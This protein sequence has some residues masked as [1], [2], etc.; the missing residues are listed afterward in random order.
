MPTHIRSSNLIWIDLEMTGLEPEE[1]KIL[2]IAVIVTDKHLNILAEGPT[3]AIHQKPSA[4]NK[5]DEWNVKQHTKSGLIERVKQSRITEAVAEE[6]ILEFLSHYVPAKKSPICGN[7][8]YQDR[9]FLYKYMPKLEQYFHY[10]NLD[11]S[12]IKIL[13]RHWYPKIIKGHGKE[14]KHEALSDIYDSIN[15][16]KFYREHLFVKRKEKN[17]SK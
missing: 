10:R 11:V 1:D 14:S 16:L 13:A 17:D 15:E 4:L 5:M 6:K 2:E 9:R 8:I 12:T 3:F 7:T